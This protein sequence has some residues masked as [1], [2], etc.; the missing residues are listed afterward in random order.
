MEFFWYQ[1]RRKG[2]ACWNQTHSSLYRM[3]SKCYCKLCSVMYCILPTKI[4]SERLRLWD[5]SPSGCRCLWKMWIANGR[6]RLAIV[7]WSSELNLSSRMMLWLRQLVTYKLFSKMVMSYRFCTC[8]IQPHHG[9]VK[10]PQRKIKVMFDASNLILTSVGSDTTCSLI[11]LTAGHAG[12]PCNNVLCVIQV[13]P[14]ENPEGSKH[15]GVSE[16]RHCI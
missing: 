13:S 2:T 3:H 1:K 9:K 6:L 5:H 7:S 4:C 16:I 15:V 11:L 14:W 8:N 10:Q 12:N